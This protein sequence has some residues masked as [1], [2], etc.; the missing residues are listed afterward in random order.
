MFYFIFMLSQLDIDGEILDYSD[1]D[2]RG[3]RSRSYGTGFTFYINP[4]DMFW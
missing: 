3:R 2:N 4:F 1:E